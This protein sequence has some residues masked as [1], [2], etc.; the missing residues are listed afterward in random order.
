MLVCRG[1]C[2]DIAGF[3]LQHEVKQSCKNV[4]FKLCLR[5]HRSRRLQSYS[6]QYLLYNA[7]TLWDDISLCNLLF[8]NETVFY[9]GK[10]LCVIG[11]C[12]GKNLVMWYPS[13]YRGLLNTQ[14]NHK[15]FIIQ[16]QLISCLTHTPPFITLSC[17]TEV[18]LIQSVKH[19]LFLLFTHMQ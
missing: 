17:S 15:S 13:W 16:S 4:K 11:L 3:L 10:L 9:S 19:F 5:N 12:I 6:K 8:G 14:M 1:Y 2:K 18:K 7:N